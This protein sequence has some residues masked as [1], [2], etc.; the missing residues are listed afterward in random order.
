MKFQIIIKGTPVKGRKK[1]RLDFR[2]AEAPAPEK[3]CAAVRL[4]VAFKTLHG[5]EEEKEEPNN[6]K[7]RSGAL[8]FLDLYSLFLFA[9]RVSID[10]TAN[11]SLSFFK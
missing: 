8:F 1:Q 3:T 11:Q 9:V 5:P 7:Q 6:R 4:F 2:M 10:G